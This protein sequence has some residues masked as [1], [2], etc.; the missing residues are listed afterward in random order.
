M[1]ALAGT[2]AA[3]SDRYT[4]SGLEGVFGDVVGRVALSASAGVAAGG[5]VGPRRVWSAAF[6]AETSE[7]SFELRTTWLQDTPADSL[8]PGAR[9]PA[10]LDAQ[11]TD[12]ELHARHRLRR[13]EVSATG[14]IRFGGT[15]NDTPQWLSAEV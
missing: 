9:A 8:L 4:R 6:G 1:A 15:M 10:L 2:A 7:L 11:Y 13:V 3:G 5:G 14:G 12:G